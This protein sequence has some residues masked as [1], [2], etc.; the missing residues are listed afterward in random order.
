M[1]IAFVGEK[2]RF[3]VIYLDDITIFSKFD[4]E[5]LQH[6][7]HI[8]QKCRRYLISL[9]HKNSH[10]SM[11]EGKILGHIISIGGINID[12][13]RVDV[14]QQFGI[15]RNKKAIQSFIGKI[16]FL[17]NF[18]PYF[19][20]IIRPITNMLNKEDDIKWS[21]EAISFFKIIK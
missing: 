3:M 2:E 21:K 1:D 13:E 17:R 16:I 8:F 15:P 6:L 5:H 18:V 14:I 19:A 12:L 9:N 10:F 20:K 4:D 7:K 11:L